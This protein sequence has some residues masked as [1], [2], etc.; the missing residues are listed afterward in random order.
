MPNKV[1]LT[2]NTSFYIY[3]FRLSLVK[4]LLDNNYK[5]IVIGPIDQYSNKLIQIGCEFHPIYINSK[6][7]NPFMD[8]ILFLKYFYYYSVLKPKL[9][10]NFT[11]KS[12]IY[13]TLAATLFNLK[14]I[15]NISGLG[16]GFVKDNF[17]TLIIKL[18]YKFTQ[19][20]AH[21]VYFQNIDN[22]KFFIDNKIVNKYKCRL[23]PGSGVDLNKFIFSKLNLISNK[24]VFL[25]NSRMLY[26]KG[27]ELLFQ[28][29]LR[30]YHE[31]IN[32]EIVL[33]GQSDVLNKDAISNDQI[34]KWC[35]YPFFNYK[36]FTDEIKYAIDKSHCII[37]PSFYQEG[38]P[39]SLLEALSVGRP[40]ITTDMPGCRDTVSNS[41]G[42][43]VKPNDVDSLYD[44]M[45]RMINLPYDK[46]VL[47]GENSRQLAVNIFDDKIVINEYMSC[48]KKCLKNYK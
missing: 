46:L 20:R 23:L 4:I 36:G 2:A 34:S 8:F 10:L 25:F 29:G 14:I 11:T 33:Y 21:I 47:M 7:V 22:Y 32:F 18:L 26:S 3:N 27:V 28:S 37:L 40:I 9:V 39:K 38:T 12:N 35:M 13:S 17:I 48:I 5:V 19:N 31:N 41:N 15:N 1:V 24:F 6:S 16:I 42:F 43:I 30:L 45:K 44:S